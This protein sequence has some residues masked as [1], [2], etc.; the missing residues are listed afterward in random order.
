M[1]YSLLLIPTRPGSLDGV[2]DLAKKPLEDSAH[3]SPRRSI[4]PT[5]R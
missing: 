3:C 5:P 2:R 4:Q 1:L